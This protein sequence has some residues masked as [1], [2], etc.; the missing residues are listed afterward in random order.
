MK[1]LWKLLTISMVLMLANETASAQL[2]FFYNDIISDTSLS[3][4]ARIDRIDSLFMADSVLM[5][6][7]IYGSK[8]Y[9][10]W[11]S[12]VTSKLDSNGEIDVYSTA[13]YSQ[14]SSPSSNPFAVILPQTPPG[15]G[16]I[17]MSEDANW[18]TIG[19]DQLVENRRRNGTFSWRSLGKM[20]VIWPFSHDIIYA[21]SDKGGLFVTKDGGDNWKAVPIKFIDQNGN[22]VIPP[23]IGV[24]DIVVHPTDEDIVYVSTAYAWEYGSGVFKTTDG[25]ETWER[26][27]KSNLSG[28]KE[29]ANDIFR[30]IVMTSGDPDHLYA[31]TSDKLYETTDGGTTGWNL[32]PDPKGYFH[33]ADLYDLEVDPDPMNSDIVYL[34]GRSVWK[35][36]LSGGSTVVEDYR[37]K[38]GIPMINDFS[39]DLFEFPDFCD[40]NGCTVNEDLLTQKIWGGDI[41]A[42]NAS[43]PD[44]ASNK[45]TNFCDAGTSTIHTG[46]KLLKNTTRQLYRKTRSVQVNG[47]VIQLPLQQSATAGNTFKLELQDLV[48]P[49]NTYLRIE[50]SNTNSVQ[51]LY[52]SD[53]GAGYSIDVNGFVTYG[54]TNEHKFD[55]NVTHL[56][57]IAGA[58]LN[59]NEQDVLSLRKLQLHLPERLASCRVEVKGTDLYA[60]VARANRESYIIKSDATHTTF[61]ELFGATNSTYTPGYMDAFIVSRVPNVHS[62]MIE[63][64]TGSVRLH[65]HQFDL[66]NLASPKRVMFPYSN[67]HLHADYRDFFKLDGWV[68]MAHDGGL[69]RVDDSEPYPTRVYES[70][71]GKGLTIGHFW[72]IDRKRHEH[73]TLIG[74]GIMHQGHFYRDNREYSWRGIHGGGD[75]ADL[76]IDNDWD[77][78]GLTG[79]KNSVRTGFGGTHGS[80]S[81]HW[82]TDNGYN[83]GPGSSKGYGTSSFD[84]P[85]SYH[86]LEQAA[87]GYYYACFGNKIYRSTNTLGTAWP[88]SN[89]P[90]YTFSTTDGNNDPYTGMVIETMAFAPSDPSIVYVAMRDA[91]WNYKE[92]KEYRLYRG[93]VTPSGVMTFE[94]IPFDVPAFD[95]S[96]A[97]LAVSYDDPGILW[98]TMMG[99]GADKLYLSENA[100]AAS[101]FSVSFQNLSPDVY[102]IIGDM[103]ALNVATVPYTNE[104]IFLGTEYGI[105]YGTKDDPLGT[106]WSWERY[107][108]IVPKVDWAIDGANSNLPLGEIADIEMDKRDNKIITSVYGRGLW[109][110]DLP[111]ADKK[112]IPEYINTNTTWANLE[113]RVPR[114]VV[115]LNGATLTIQ[116]CDLSFV[117]DAKIVVNVGC[118]L[119]VNNSILSNSCGKEWDGILV[120]GNGY[121][122]PQPGGGEVVL[123]NS[124]LENGEY[125]VRVGDDDVN[126][127]GILKVEDCQFRNCFVGVSYYRYAYQQST[128]DG[129]INDSKFYC[130]A[131]VPGHN[132]KGVHAHIGLYAV[133]G[134][135]IQGCS[136]F[137]YMT[138]DEITNGSKGIG[139]D[140][141]D[142]SFILKR[143]SDHLACVGIGKRNVFNGL[144]YGVKLHG[145]GYQT[146]YVTKIMESDFQNN[147][148]AI[149]V[150]NQYGTFMW[151]NTLQWGDNDDNHDLIPCL[152]QTNQLCQGLVI[153]GS[154]AFQFVDNTVNFQSDAFLFEGIRVVSGNVGSP[155]DYSKIQKNLFD[156]KDDNLNNIESLT[157]LHYVAN[158]FEGDNTNLY[159]NCNTYSDYFTDWVVNGPLALQ[160]SEAGIAMDPRNNFSQPCSNFPPGTN[161]LSFNTFDVD[162]LVIAGVEYMLDAGAPPMTPC[163]EGL[164]NFLT[165]GGSYAGCDARA[166]TP[167]SIHCGSSGGGEGPKQ[168]DNNTMGLIPDQTS[169]KATVYPNPSKGVFHISLDQEVRLERVEVYSLSGHKVYTRKLNPN[170]ATHSIDLRNLVNGMYVMKM[171][172]NDGVLQQQL[173]VNQN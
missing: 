169:G 61:T 14:F 129:Y 95:Q 2:H 147:R 12:Q 24:R 111:C 135:L 150:L 156:L 5:N 39:D 102:N 20:D 155:A 10:R 51:V 13:L 134:L 16:N 98:V 97:D 116:D 42:Y 125:G 122:N 67:A 26:Q 101:P 64:Y 121:G 140:V 47:S 159:V 79:N 62:S 3:Y 168:P 63:V 171:I 165:A 68:Y 11:R 145:G 35:V 115:L 139:I 49:A 38:L 57:V 86:F 48:V 132:G 113:Q 36:D 17:P 9:A 160:E 131:P 88:N 106:T 142:G 46:V 119:I 138:E 96:I 162:P 60:W 21:G 91:H 32:I 110:S 120:Y 90:N 170:M 172:S 37:Q 22:T 118:K 33:M 25:G 100:Q 70:I 133:R 43:Q 166:Y 164:V 77:G 73:H 112:T 148:I 53:A 34:S 31:I 128:I 23:V 55:F 137:N 83:G 44:F 8:Y 141:W 6:D 107:S 50:A 109:E 52:D 41:V 4:Q 126:S 154:P 143:K 123:T 93:T 136:F 144:E 89:S 114:D 54:G 28:F 76:E 58:T 92:R 99:S 163:I 65:R 30:K 81:V 124:V 18:K 152:S 157:P 161:G 105:L 80:K 82:N 167:A 66:S 78:V 15:S 29:A 74:G 56:Y 151:D 19:P 27:H 69:I 40:A 173:M 75:G 84:I 85:S 1:T 87:D 108:K 127:G 158:I 149:S 117:Q 45:W 59:F 104:E 71:S 7:S 153:E 130:D 103:A 72:S 146:D 94:G